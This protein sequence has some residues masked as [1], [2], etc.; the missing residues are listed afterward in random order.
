MPSCLP[1]K[2]PCVRVFLVFHIIRCLAIPRFLK[3][4]AIVSRFLLW[5]NMRLGRQ[6]DGCFM[7]IGQ[8]IREV[9]KSKGVT[10]VSLSKQMCCTRANIYKIFSKPSL[11]TS[12]LA[13]LSQI[14]QH[15]FFADLSEMLNS[16]SK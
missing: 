14:L 12:Q 9:A 4:Q 11:D 15:D 1:G 5:D 7:Y 16:D 13:R 10:I 8:R 2:T 3:W 6:A